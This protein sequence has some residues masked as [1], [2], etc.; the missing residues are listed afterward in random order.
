MPYKLILL[1]LLYLPNSAFSQSNTLLVIGDSLSAAYGI[2]EQQGWVALLQKKLDKIESNY[3]VINASIS[4]ETSAGGL[5]RLP[6]LL[7]KTNPT[8]V[9]IT[10]GANDGLR[11]LPLKQMR[12][13]LS[14]MI[15]LSQKHG[16]QV[17]L[18]GMQLP[19]NYG[20]IYNQNFF[21]SFSILAKEEKT[22]YL[23]F[24]L[25]GLVNQ[26]K[27]FQP[28]GLHPVA[29]AQPIILENIWTHLQTLVAQNRD[30]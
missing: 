10:L 27:W 26:K 24:L 23:P 18:A 19:P 5:S 14:Q 15:Q 25:T 11:G 7:Q 4:G 28:D 6:Q 20:K 22:A 29:A 30:R 3:Q 17:L 12:D 9:I 13:N 8:I 1:I 2:D 21:N 16:R